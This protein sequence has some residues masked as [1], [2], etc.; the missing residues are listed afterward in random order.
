MGKITDLKGHCALVT[1][2]TGGIGLEFCRTLARMGCTLALTDID[3]TRLAEAGEILSRDF[4][5]VEIVCIPTD[6]TARDA[7]DIIYTSCGDRGIDPDI[8]INNAGI[9]SFAGAADIPERKIDCFI[10]LHMRALTMLC[11]RFAT[12]R[13]GHGGGKILN[14]SSMSCWMPMPGL[15]MYA[16]TKA[17]IRVFSRALHYETRDYGVT[18]TTACPGGIATNL[19]GLPD[20]LKRLAVAI[21]VL[22]TPQRFARKAIRKMLKGKRQYINGW[23]NR[24]SIVVVAMTPTPVRMMVKHRLL[25]KGIKKP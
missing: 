14:M 19:F 9:F 7:I 13:M 3:A 11:R 10:D 2:A 22:D 20:N 23:L 1:G 21:G 15:S 25:D 18:V 24:I 17:Y 8:L 4:P 16:A 6:L 5:G 12:Q